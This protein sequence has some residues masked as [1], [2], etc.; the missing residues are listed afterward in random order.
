M[1]AR[2]TPGEP[3]Q[4]DAKLKNPHGK[5]RALKD[6]I[7]EMSGIS[8]FTDRRQISDCY[9]LGQGGKGEVTA[10]G[11]RVSSGR[12]KSVLKLG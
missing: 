11:Y 9:R 5:D 7:Y 12:A 1:D 6:P 4:P 10:D 3:C 8:K 2:C